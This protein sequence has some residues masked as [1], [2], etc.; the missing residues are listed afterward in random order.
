[1]ELASDEKA[2]SNSS[3]EIH[4]PKAWDMGICNLHLIVPLQILG[5]C[6]PESSLFRT[7]LNG[8]YSIPAVSV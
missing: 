3:F 6:L 2:S 8:H 5:P 1:M 4:R 7:L